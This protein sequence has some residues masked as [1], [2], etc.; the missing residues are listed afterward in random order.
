MISYSVKKLKTD[1][2]DFDEKLRGSKLTSPNMLYIVSFIIYY[3]HKMMLTTATPWAIYIRS[4]IPILDFIIIFL[5]LLKI[6]LYDKDDGKF[7]ALIFISFSSVVLS[8]FFLSTSTVNPLAM[9]MYILFIAAARNVDFKKL[10]LAVFVSS[11]IVISFVTCMSQFGRIPDLIYFYHTARHSFGFIYPTDYAAHWLFAFL[12]YFYFRDGIFK[13]YDLAV[14]VISALFLMFF[15]EA[16]TSFA[17]IILLIIL[18]LLFRTKW[19][20]R[21]FDK[22]KKLFIASPLI[23]AL[24]SILSTLIFGSYLTSKGFEAENSIIHRLTTGMKMISRYGFHIRGN[25]VIENGFG[26]STGTVTD[27][28]FIDNSYV[29][30]ALNYGVVMLAVILAYLTFLIIRSIGKKDHALLAVTVIVLIDCVLEHHLIDF[31]YNIFFF[32]ALAKL[33]DTFQNNI[34]TKT[35]KLSGG[36]S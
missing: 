10:C 15:C 20:Y 29:K 8:M 1:L 35:K 4:G 7:K 5:L 27:Y 3:I 19:I 36:N 24:F 17:M 28:T 32:A 12:A 13:W 9:C 11:M 33:N 22:M 14:I 34:K 18:S 25:Y 31:S 21:S 26:G 2:K 16:K 23:M 30:V 6:F